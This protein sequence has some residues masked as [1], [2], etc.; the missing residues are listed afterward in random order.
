MQPQKGQFP[1]QIV[2]G[3]PN[4]PAPP[5]KIKSGASSV[6]PKTPSQRPVGKLPKGAIE[7][8]GQGGSVKPAGQGLMPDNEF[9]IKQPGSA[10]AYEG[11]KSG[12]LPFGGAP[13]IPGFGAGG[14]GMG[15]QIK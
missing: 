9:K 2:P 4:P 11:W 8:I 12:K 13:G 15:D 1:Q 6:T 5:I 14:L 7:K 3:V 10:K